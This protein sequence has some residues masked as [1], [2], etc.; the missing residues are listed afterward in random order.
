MG[1]QQTTKEEVR[2]TYRKR[3][4]RYVV[5][6]ELYLLRRGL[7]SDPDEM[8]GAIETDYLVAFEA[9]CQEVSGVARTATQVNCQSRPN[10]YCVLQKSP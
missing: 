8:L 5:K 7:V 2:R 4:S 3:H 9:I 1:K 6:K 10:V